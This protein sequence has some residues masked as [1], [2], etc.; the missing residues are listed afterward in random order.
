MNLILI[1]IIIIL[2]IVIFVVLFFIFYFIFSQ[3][4]KYFKSNLQIGNSC[5]YYPNEDDDK[6]CKVVDI[7]DNVVKIKDLFGVIYETNIENIST[8]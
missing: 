7:K 5:I 3:K 2:P 4:E 8:P 6:F 1:I